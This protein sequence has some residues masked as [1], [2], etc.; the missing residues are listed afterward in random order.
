MDELSRASCEAYRSIVYENPHFINYFK[1]ATPE[2]ELG[3]LNIGATCVSV[4]FNVV[5]ANSML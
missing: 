5:N 1:S 3:N 4:D 2:A